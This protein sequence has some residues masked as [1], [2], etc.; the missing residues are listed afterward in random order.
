MAAS[1]AINNSLSVSKSKYVASQLLIK[2]GRFLSLNFPLIKWLR[3]KSWKVLVIFPIPSS[4]YTITTSGAT[5][6]SLGSNFHSKSL[7]LIPISTLV[8]SNWH[9]S[10][11]AKK[12]PEY[13][14][15]NPYTSPKSCVALLSKSTIKGLS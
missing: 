2:I 10:T 15:L 7:G 14:K 13:T 12:F 4:E 3:Y 8:V 5:N 9:P 1:L 6:S 11:C